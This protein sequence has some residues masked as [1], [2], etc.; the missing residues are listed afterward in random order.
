[1]IFPSI[2]ASAT[3]P[4]GRPAAIISTPVAE[5]GPAAEAAAADEEEGPET[6]DGEEGCHAM[7]CYRHKSMGIGWIALMGE[8]RNN[9]E[10]MGYSTAN[11]VIAITSIKSQPNGQEHHEEK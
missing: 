8:R 10:F 11:A 7:H 3:R 9:D 4:F 2:R 1:M 5:E 6:V